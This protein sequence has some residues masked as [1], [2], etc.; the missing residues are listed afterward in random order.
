MTLRK[1]TLRDWQAAE[2]FAAG[3][4]RDGF[5]VRTMSEERNGVLVTWAEND[6]QEH[7]DDE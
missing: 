7:Q 6:A 1:K 2:I 3:L 4:N 5:Q